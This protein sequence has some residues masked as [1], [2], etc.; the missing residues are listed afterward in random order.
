M[1]MNPISQLGFTGLVSL[2]AGLPAVYSILGRKPPSQRMGPKGVPETT[3]R[4]SSCRALGCFQCRQYSA[5]W[6]LRVTARSSWTRWEG[7]PQ[8]GEPA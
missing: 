8:G 4:T 3:K 5:P 1:V 7:R 6:A 2:T